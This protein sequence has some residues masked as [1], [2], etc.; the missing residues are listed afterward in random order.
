VSDF[1]AFLG[2]ETTNFPEN[3][4]RINPAV[5]LLGE[6]SKR[7]RVRSVT[8]A[9]MSAGSGNNSSLASEMIKRPDDY[10]HKI[11]IR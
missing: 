10:S 6:F 4:F 5:G 7:T 1:V 11:H 3:C 8:L 9:A 2:Q